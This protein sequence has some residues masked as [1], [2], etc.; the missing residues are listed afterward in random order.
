MLVGRFRVKVND[1]CVDL[2][3][4]TPLLVPLLLVLEV[5]GAL[6]KLE[7]SHDANEL[8]ESLIDVDSHCEW[9]K[10]LFGF[11]RTYFEFGNHLWQSTRDMEFSAVGSTLAPSQLTP[12]RF[13]FTHH[14]L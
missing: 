8:V 4:A 5:E 11:A 6:G 7:F 10:S 12:A 3:D 14:Q 1:L 2:K 13:H 9:K